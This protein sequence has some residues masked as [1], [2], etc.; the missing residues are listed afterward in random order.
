MHS[1]W[2]VT[3]DSNRDRYTFKLVRAADD[4]GILTPAETGIAAAPPG[5]PA[6]L[7]GQAAAQTARFIVRKVPGTH[8]YKCKV[9]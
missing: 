2:L 5:N 6:P 3:N 4:D 7:R 9:S 1:Q 8:L